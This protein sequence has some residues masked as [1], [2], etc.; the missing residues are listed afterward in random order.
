MTPQQRQE[1]LAKRWELLP[2]Y[3]R[4]EIEHLRRVRDDLRRRLD[5]IYQPVTGESTV[6]LNPHSEY[7]RDIGRDAD[8]SFTLDVKGGETNATACRRAIRVSIERDYKGIARALSIIA[9]GSIAVQGLA[10]NAMRV[11]PVDY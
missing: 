3:V 8:V 6:I 10:S 5:N 11:I 2:S 9:G 1:A 4:E 7:A